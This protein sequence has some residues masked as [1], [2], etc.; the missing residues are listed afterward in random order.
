[1]GEMIDFPSDGGSCPG[2]AARPPGGRGPGVVLIQEWWG[3]VEH[4]KDVCE[5]FAGEGF[6]AVAP[7]LY[8]G[9]VASEPDEAG[10]L[11]MGLRIDVAARDM[12]AAAAWLRAGEASSTPVGVVGFCM[13]GALA[14]YA[15]GTTPHV[16]ATVAFY[17]PLGMPSVQGLDPASIS[18]AVLCHFA[19]EDHASTPEQA[20]DFERRLDEAGVP[21]EVHWYDASGHA[22]FNDARP[23]AYRPEAAQR[24]WTRT[25]SFLRTHLATTPAPV[26]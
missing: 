7:D 15:A 14:L 12:A 11:A 8:H 25:L 18:G 23:E 17:P 3:L 4:I 20:A 2:Y 9:A 13:G 10:K 24:A 6:V 1:M 5:R 16:A 26:G 21:I 19:T 22:F